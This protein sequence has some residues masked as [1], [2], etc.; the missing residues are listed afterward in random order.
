MEGLSSYELNDYELR[1]FAKEL[2]KI[3]ADHN[4]KIGSCAENIDLDECGIV[5]NSCIDRELIEKLI[6]CKL[7]VSKD[8]E[9]RYIGSLNRLPEIISMVDIAIL[10]D[11]TKE[12]DRFAVFENGKLTSK[13]KT[14]P[15]WYKRIFEK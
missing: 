9:R 7:D 4:I 11:N 14:Q 1:K 12:F 5:H 6:G 2:S 10:Y 8:V 13:E 15:D 3:A